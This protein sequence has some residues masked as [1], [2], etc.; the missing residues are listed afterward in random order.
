MIDLS[1]KL[2]SK[3]HKEIKE[4]RER[5]LMRQCQVLDMVCNNE[6]VLNQKINPRWV[7]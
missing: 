2:F 7:V 4:A 6:V 1:R 5:L 3:K